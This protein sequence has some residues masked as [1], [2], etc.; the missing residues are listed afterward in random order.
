IL[1]ANGR[2]GRHAAEAFWNA[3]WHVRLFDRATDDLMEKAHGV[4]VIVNAWN[5]PYT[6]W[7]TQLPQLTREV[8]AAAKISGAMVLIPGNIYVYGTGIPP[9]I[10]N[11]TPV[12]AQNP[13]GRIR[14]KMEAAYRTAGVKTIVLRAGD[15][16]DTQASGNWFDEVIT[17]KLAKGKVV[18]PGDPDAMHAWA[19]LPDLTR[20]AVALAEKRENL[21]AFQEVLFSGYTLSVR[22]IAALAEQATNRSLKVS[23]MN[24]A[25]LWIAA[26]FWS[27]GR[28]LLEMRYLWSRPHSIDGAQVAALLPD[29]KQTDHL[30]AIAS[31]IGHT[32]V[33]PNHAV[34]RGGNNLVTE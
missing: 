15:F 4:D 3:G 9:V 26:P 32:N 27:M 24:W 18:S 19:Y 31:A 7:A 33:D 10:T 17:A 28:R 5:P 23:K 20:A 12:E 14:I 16:I 11:E 29:F 25:P 21:E 2:F 8:I 22:E 30:T 1:G 6:K 34:T 13:L